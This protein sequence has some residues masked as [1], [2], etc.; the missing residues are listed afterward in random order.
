LSDLAVFISPL[1][2]VGCL[3]CGLDLHIRH[4]QFFTR[5][6]ITPVFLLP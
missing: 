3:S 6:I 4:L 2:L 1:S 5:I